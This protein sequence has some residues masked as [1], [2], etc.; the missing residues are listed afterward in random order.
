MA[1]K[2]TTNR[3]R[4]NGRASQPRAITKQDPSETNKS[5]EVARLVKGAVEEAK[6]VTAS[7]PKVPAQPIQLT[8]VEGQ[9]LVARA[10]ELEQVQLALGQADIEMTELEEKRTALR[11][12]FFSKKAEFKQRIHGVVAGRGI[13]PTS[14]NWHLDHQT[15]AIVPTMPR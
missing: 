7:A 5:E 15:P 1:T 14:A 4:G 10:R 2:K 12:F 6:K 9:E 8:E 13:E 11:K 3:K